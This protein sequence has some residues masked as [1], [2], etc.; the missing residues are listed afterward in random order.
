MIKISIDRTQEAAEEAIARKAAKMVPALLSEMTRLM[1][2]LQKKIVGEKLQGQVLAH[3][4]GKL[5][6]SIKALKA[7][8]D[9]ERIV[10]VVEGAGGPAWYG[11]V[12]EFGGKT[13][14]LI[15]PKYK[16]ALAFF[17]QGVSNVTGGRAILRGMKQTSN[18]KKRSSSISKFSGL[19]GVV[20]QAVRHPPLPQ[21]SFMK[22]SLMEMRDQIVND[23][24]LV[25]VKAL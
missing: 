23:L 19:G 25:L 24:Q 20:V 10:G 22:T 8:S 14:Y 5:S 6:R 7:F 3:R 13:S 17:P 16:K 18:L 11:Q 15:L 1:L 9:G 2:L 4:T 21:R 12:H